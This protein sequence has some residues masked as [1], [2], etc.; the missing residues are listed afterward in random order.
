M[1]NDNDRVISNVI[2]DE[3]Q[4][5]FSLVFVSTDYHWLISMATG[6][7]VNVMPECSAK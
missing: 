4:Y 7:P 3:R 6:T 5:T 2:D 1:I